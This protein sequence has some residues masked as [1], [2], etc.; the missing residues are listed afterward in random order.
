MRS[1]ELDALKRALSNWSF[2]YTIQFSPKGQECGPKFL[3]PSRFGLYRRVCASF[4]IGS[5]RRVGLTKTS[6][7]GSIR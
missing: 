3:D 5:V 4:E 1:G 2:G 6:V 7:S